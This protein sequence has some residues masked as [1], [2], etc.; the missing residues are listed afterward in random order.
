MT[1]ADAILRKFARTLVR[2]SLD[3][4]PGDLFVI[5]TTTLA[6]PL[7]RDVYSEALQAGANPVVRLTFDG[8]EDLLLREATEEQLAWVSPLDQLESERMAARLTIQAPFNTRGVAARSAEA[9]RMRA[10]ALA[11]PAGVAAR[12]SAAGELRWCGTLFPTHALAQEAEMSLPDYEAFVYAAMFLDLDDPIAAWQEFSQKQQKKVDY[13]N[14]IEELRIVA[15]D[16][17][18]RMRVGGRKWMNS[19]GHRNFPSGEVFTGPVE[20]SVN[21]HIRFTYPAIRGG[22]AVEDVR[23][24][25]EN[26]RLVDATAARGEEILL[27]EIETDEGARFLGEVA[28]GNNYGIQRFT[29]NTLFDEKI[30]GTCHVALGS[31]YPDTGGRNQ[32]AIHWDMVCDLRVGGAVYADGEV[33]HENGKWKV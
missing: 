20:E 12:R 6:V 17:D 9:A 15:E 26:G 3:L 29:R 23:L 5:R 31:S 30:G 19:D 7:V 27:R 8:Q 11:A 18:L 2:Y 10:R 28:I 25:F 1:L 13:L 24:K 22:A 32:S 21:G 4:Q 14:S 16:T 33:I